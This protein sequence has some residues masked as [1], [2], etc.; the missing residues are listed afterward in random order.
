ML[1]SRGGDEIN[2]ATLNGVRM[3]VSVP[4]P[5]GRGSRD[6][7]VLLREPP[8]FLD[9]QPLSTFI[10]YRD[11]TYDTYDGNNQAAGPDWYAIHFPEAVTVNCVDSV[12]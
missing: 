6:P 1:T 3:T 9:R 5:T 7:G 4:E 8:F 2:L 11:R 10:D 12:A